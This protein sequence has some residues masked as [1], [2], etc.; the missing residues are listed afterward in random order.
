M[1]IHD[2]K[3]SIVDLF[4]TVITAFMEKSSLSEST[5]EGDTTGNLQTSG[6]RVPQYKAIVDYNY[7]PSSI[8]INT[9]NTRV[10]RQ[11]IF[12]TDH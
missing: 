11:Q 12:Y 9:E 6:G 5:R 2:K 7:I 4:Q 8:R 3:N 10:G 1:P